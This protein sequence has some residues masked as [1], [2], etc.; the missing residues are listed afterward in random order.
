MQSAVKQLLLDRNANG[1]RCSRWCEIYAC[2]H[3]VTSHISHDFKLLQSKHRVLKITR[4]G[5]TA[6]K[7]FLISID[8]HSRE[9]RC[10]GRRMS[11]IS[12]AV[13]QLNHP[14][15][16]GIDYGVVHVLPDDDR[17]HRLRCIGQGFGQRH[18]VRCHTK[19][20]R[21]ERL[22]GSAEPANHLVENQQNSVSVANLP[23]TLQ[24][25]DRRYQAAG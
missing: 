17:T 16:R 5:L 23:Q 14:I 15:R 22:T 6:F 10:T 2:N 11:R 1:T 9:S 24:V 8:I 21:S 25:A 20:L 4:Q 13:K 19:C 18:D 3:S 12:V 7:E